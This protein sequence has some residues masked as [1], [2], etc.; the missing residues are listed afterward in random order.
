MEGNMYTVKVN[1]KTRTYPEGTT[2]LDIGKE[3]LSDFDNDLA[4]VFADDKLQ[5][6]FKHVKKD[7]TLKFI[8]TADPIGMMAYRRSV[9]FMMIKAVYDVAERGTLEGV[10][11]LHSLSRGVYCELE[12]SVRSDTDFLNKVKGRMQ[13][14]CRANIMI[15]KRSVSRDEEEAIFHNHGMYGKERLFRYR[16]TSRVNIYS[17]DDFED[18]F[19]GYMIGSTGILKYYDLFPYDEGFVLQLPVESAPQEV[20][21]FEPQNNL[22]KVFKEA[23]RW[24]D[25]MDIRTVS[26][27]NDAVTFGE[28]NDLVLVQEAFQEKRIGDIAD[29]IAGLPEKKFV[30]IAGP[31]S[32]SK[33]S[34]ANR[35]SI[36][37][38]THCL[39]PHL[40]SVDNFFVDR[41]HTP[42]DSNGQ[43][44]YENLNALDIEEL[45]RDLTELLSGKE[46]A[47]PTYNFVKGTKE[48]LGNTLKMDD[49]D[50]LVIEGIHCLNDALTYK[51]SQKNKYKIYIS[52]LTQLNVD[53]HNRIPTTDGRLIRRMVR[54]A[55]TR[56]TAAK[57]TIAMWPSVRR[58]EEQNIFPFQEQA[59]VMFNSALPYEL[60]VLKQ[61]CEPLLYGI[62][63]GCPE[64][65]EAKRLLKFFDYFLGFGSENLPKNSLLR[66]FVGGSCFKV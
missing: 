25:M 35:L 45:N 26:D 55:R 4:L 1:G 54:D 10:R 23:T 9:T 17:I 43:L 34:F 8:T 39:K 22:F 2:Y 30:L 20:P 33:T 19:Y 38:R 48:Y 3:F 51:L 37:L 7:C 14:I 21:P 53:E 59:D 42:V 64:Y 40:I 24:G 58:G 6:L 63:R 15:R 28:A 11:V 62:P 60:A 41:E 56:G 16:Q 13:E 36:Q 29:T 61:Y 46:V 44:D 47:M 50:I 32:S 57:D 52:A 31:S 27:L 12:G 5:E 65:Q 49:S 18:Y 66:E